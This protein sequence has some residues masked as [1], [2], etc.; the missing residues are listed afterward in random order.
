MKL[1]SDFLIDYHQQHFVGVTKLLCQLKN[2]T[3]HHKII[4]YRGNI[5]DSWLHIYYA[6][7]APSSNPIPVTERQQL[8]KCNIL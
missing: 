2:Y 5:T 6:I 3:G 4:S 7:P 1:P 8:E